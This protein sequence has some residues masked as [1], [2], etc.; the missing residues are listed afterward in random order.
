MSNQNYNDFLGLGSKTAAM[1]IGFMGGL[2][3]GMLK[4]GGADNQRLATGIILGIILAIIVALIVGWISSSL[5][6][7]WGVVFSIILIILF[8]IMVANLHRIPKISLQ[9]YM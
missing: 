1:M 3:F 4:F 6:S 2:T 5:A 7:N 9:K 8:I